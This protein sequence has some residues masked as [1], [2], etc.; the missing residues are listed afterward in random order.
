MTCPQ[1]HTYPPLTRTFMEVTDVLWKTAAGLAHLKGGYMTKKRTLTCIVC[2]KGCELTVTFDNNGEIEKIEGYTCKQG[3]EYAKNECTHPVR[4]VTTTV[5]TESGRTV[6]VKTASPIPKELIFEAMKAIN[7]VR[8]PDNRDV[9][10]GD[11]IIPNVCGTDIP[12]VATSLV[13]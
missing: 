1:R 6:S 12:V 13:F 10:I 9:R 3:E 2:P 4:T 11:V 8:I 5:K 7:A